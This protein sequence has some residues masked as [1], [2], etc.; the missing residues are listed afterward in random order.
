[1]Y[2]SAQAAATSGYSVQQVR[3]LERVG[4]IPPA[5]RAANGYREFSAS[6]ILALRTYRQLALA[7]G[8]VEARRAMRDIRTK[9]VDEAV[10]LVSAFH[11]R[12]TRARDDAL[13]AQRALAVIGGE[14]DADPDP[15]DAMTITELGAALGVRASTLRFWEQVGLVRPE[16][17]T[18]LNA[19]RYP[20]AAIREARIVAVLRAAGYGIPAIQ[21]LVRSVRELE[22][23][24]ESRA[25]LQARLDA[26]AR[27]MLALLAAG[28]GI[29]ELIAS[30]PAAP[31]SSA[32]APR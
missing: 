7:V 18:R 6:H 21:A 32:G 9:P 16:R 8:A 26:I 12:L 30:A 3:D 4:A 14:A 13:S 27:Q 17:V 23:V 29:A 25:A 19:R 31:S 22:D 10:A 11:V 5:Q 2:S 24:D 1:M 28:A 20:V 15:R